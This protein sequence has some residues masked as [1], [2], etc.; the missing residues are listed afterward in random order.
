MNLLKKL[1]PA[2]PWTRILASAGVIG[3]LSALGGC[4]GGVLLFPDNNLA[5]LM[6]VPLGGIGIA[7]GLVTGITWS[8]FSKR[9]HSLRT[10]FRWLAGFW[11]LTLLA[12]YMLD[13]EIVFVGLQVL[14]MVLGLSIVANKRLRPNIPAAAFRYR[15]VY[16]VAALLVLGTSLFPPVTHNQWMPAERRPV[17]TDLNPMPRFLFCTSP[18]LDASHSYAELEIDRVRLRMEWLAIATGA[19]LLTAILYMRNRHK[20]STNPSEL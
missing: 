18:Q 2:R 9:E 20:E 15:F 4:F 6:F 1:L 14:P 11:V 19:G 16:L 5:P 17:Y 13:C 10:E 12:S 3:Y 7:I 8:A